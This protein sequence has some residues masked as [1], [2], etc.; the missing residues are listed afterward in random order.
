M[1]GTL[2]IDTA[3]RTVA[4][5]FQQDGQTRVRTSDDETPEHSR[6][7]ID[8]IDDVTGGDREAITGIV[9]VQGPGSFTGLR[10]GIATAQSLGFAL[11][12]PVTGVPTLQLVTACAR[13]PDILAVHPAGRDEFASQRFIDGN[14]PGDFVLASADELD[15]TLIV[16]EGAEA[17][18]GRELGPTE[19]V[20]AAVSVVVPSGSGPSVDPIYARAPN[21]TKPREPFPPRGA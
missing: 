16:G 8:L 18:G 7:I 9:V 6:R 4:V 14:A 13:Q 17:L 3:S 5:A 21:I 20:T 11:G 19:R 2:A 15:H 10:I 12:V 1:T